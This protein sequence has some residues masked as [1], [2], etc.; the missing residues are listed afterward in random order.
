M[1]MSIQ[2]ATPN[3]QR[4]FL[5]S[6]TP[7]MPG[8]TV[9]A[10]VVPANPGA[11]QARFSWTVELRF[12]SHTTA[13]GVTGTPLNINRT[14]TGGHL[15]INPT[16]WGRICGGNLTI[17]VTVTI[18]GQ[19]A[20]ARLQGLT[21]KGTHP[22]LTAVRA[23]LGTDILRRI[24]NQESS[25]HQFGADS[26]PLFSGDGLG[27][28]GIMQITP[29]SEAQRWNWRTNVQAGIDKY[30]QCYTLT[31]TYVQSVR[32]STQFAAL[33]TALNQVR[34]QQHLPALTVTVPEWSD[35][36]RMRD[37]TRGY[38]GWAGHDPV[39][40]NLHL[41]EYKLSRDALG[42]LQVNLIP[43]TTRAE[44]IW[45]QVP[46]SERPHSSGDPDYVAHVL[47]QTP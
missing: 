11:A 39:V 12:P 6:D 19:T 2:L 20:T 31:A 9:D 21:I 47:A 15:V 13:H 41:H 10:T 34:A 7:Q 3:N 30:N 23:A 42:R 26:W 32:N 17:N 4:E 40:P 22:N 36:Q 33:V 38:N 24:A 1:V 37:A 44:A 27:G 35:D 28:A 18:A 46:T 25:F 29:A 5:I 14:T 16:D 45:V 8:L 43:N